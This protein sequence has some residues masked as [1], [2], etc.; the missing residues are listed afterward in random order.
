MIVQTQE[1]VSS[2]FRQRTAVNRALVFKEAETANE[3]EQIRALNHRVFAEEV[4]QHPV[5]RSG[6]LADRF[7]GQSRYFIAIRDGIVIGMISANPG[8][9]FSVVKRLPDPHVLGVFKRPL[10]VRLLAIEPCERHQAVLAG[11]LWQLYE[12]AETHGFSHLLISAIE[13][14]ESMYRKLGFQPLG[15]PVPEGAA[16]F[17]PMVMPVA[18]GCNPKVR[19]I[20]LHRRH[21][22]RTRRQAHTISLLPGPA[23][24]HSKVSEAFRSRPA[25][26]RSD[27]FIERFERARTLLKQFLTG[28]EVAILPGGG[29]LAND[30]V[31]ANLKTIFQD[32]PGLVISNGEFGERLTRHASAAHLRFRHLKFGWGDPWS[33]SAIERAFKEKPAW[34]WA[35][36]LETSTGVLNNVEKLVRLANAGRCAVALDCVSGI[37]ASQIPS[38]SGP[39]YIAAG[40]SGKAIAAYAGLAFVYTNEECRDRLASKILPASFDILNGCRTEGPQSTISSPLIW[41]LAAALEEYYGSEKEIAQRFE[42][43]RC[44]GLHTRRLLRSASIEPLVCDAISAPNV[45]TFVSP[46]P[47]FPTKCLGAGYEIAHESAYLKERGWAQIA[48]MGEVTRESLEGLFLALRSSCSGNLVG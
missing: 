40:V 3:F 43:Y 33:V 46:D 7:E 45:T 47:S 25:S 11:L 12:F 14:R 28:S 26:H 16:A 18:E 34:V 2:P 13:N 32:S 44:M 4:A 37:G 31:A 20:E 19:Q 21:W 8:P 10:E 39:I 5:Q 17:I 6:L 30:A 9:S 41:A 38:E 1:D 24:I 42:H 22:H 29:T 35:V 15:Q 36:Q 27:V 23:C 48:T